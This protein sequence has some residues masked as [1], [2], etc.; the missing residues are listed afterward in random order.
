MPFSSS[1]HLA[2][3]FTVPALAA[4]GAAAVTIPVAIH[5]L[6][7]MRRQPVTWGA[8]RFL[9]L[10]YRQQ[11]NKLRLENWL[12]L[13]VR[14]LI[15]LLLG[16]ALSGPVLTG[17]AGGLGGA[18][19]NSGRV[20]HLII[21][22][23]LASGA[24]ETAERSRFDRHLA[25]A[26]QVIDALEPRDRVALWLAGRPARPIIEDPTT[27]REELHRALDALTPRFGGSAL[28]AA[29][30]A[31][32]EKLA[33]DQ[34]PSDR[35]VV[36]VLSDLAGGSDYWAQATP[37]ALQSLG[38][39]AQ[40]LISESSPE[41]GNVQITSLQ[42]R[43]TLVLSRSPDGGSAGVVNITVAL[44][45]FAAGSEAAEAGV[46]LRLLD[47]DG[48]VISESRR[49]ASWAAGQVETTLNVA[50]PLGEGG[51]D[52]AGPVVIE[53]TLEPGLLSDTLAADNVRLAAVE[54]R[55][56]LRIGL[57]DEATDARDGITPR[58]FIAQ[59]LSPLTGTG[60]GMTVQPLSPATL[61]RDTIETLDAVVLLRPDLLASERWDD[62]ARFARQG[63]LVW[64]VTPVAEGSAVWSDALRRAFAL[65]WR[66]GLDPFDLAA[67]SGGLGLDTQKPAPE[68]LELVGANWSELLRP[69]RVSRK[70]ELLVPEGEA[71]LALADR[72]DTSA[73]PTP[74]PGDPTQSG[75]TRRA[76]LAAQP[77]GDGLVLLLA[78]ALDADWTNLPTKPLFV[79]LLH[80]TLRGVLGSSPRGIATTVAGDQPRL[81]AGWADAASL[82]AT[83]SDPPTNPAEA[84]A[85]LAVRPIGDVA[86]TP[87]EALTRPGVYRALDAGDQPV[88]A[89]LAVNADAAAGDTRPASE[90]Q[91]TQWLSGLGPWQR[92]NLGGLAE[93]L[94]AR[95][96]RPNIGWGLL[97][98]VLALVLLETILAR[99][100]S[101]A[102]RESGSGL[103][104][105]V[106]GS[107]R[108]LRDDAG[109]ADQKAAN[110]GRAA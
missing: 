14:C 30:E 25:A 60:S 4:A 44:R 72:T 39:R 105:R 55:A 36:A 82:R 38:E 52:G 78:A 101:H 43:R 92:L 13:A 103:G 48:Q 107:L 85:A 37:A 27:D 65:E 11:K 28:P 95:S 21:D 79:P 83:D 96:L 17:C 54:A 53:A 102:K 7:R 29:L 22:D 109:A 6:S 40:V 57:I 3:G 23:A 74:P 18:F 47:A 34:T 33:L 68:A 100:A 69:V 42:P 45:R 71:W 64:V 81:G 8:M 73:D 70:I 93:Q 104:R 1:L 67:A 26:K 97:W 41:V 94:A 35:A 24:K 86:R 77:T 15:A 76:L 50:L 58:D 19:D 89:L 98:V 12:L 99:T 75:N 2:I 84:D 90:Q 108:H 16:L 9:Q 61:D 87:A 10:A 51:A 66:I 56:S 32:G 106:I 63:G 5:I 62:L 49:E 88:G 91:V 31:V 46:A 110:T 59:A 20:V 80:E